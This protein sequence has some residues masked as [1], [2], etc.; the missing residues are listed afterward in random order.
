MHEIPYSEDCTYGCENNEIDQNV[1]SI[2]FFYYHLPFKSE[3][4][5]VTVA[6]RALLPMTTLLSQSTLLI[7]INV[8]QKVKKKL[9]RK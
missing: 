1:C 8:I 5:F 9:N 2:N 6:V 4:F 3:F 7:A